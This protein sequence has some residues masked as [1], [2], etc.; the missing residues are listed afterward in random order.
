MANN[1]KITSEKLKSMNPRNI[2]ELKTSAGFCH[3][4][5][6]EKLTL[7]LKNKTF[8]FSPITNANDIDEANLHK[9]DGKNIYT[10]CLCNSDTEKIP[11]WYLY[12]GITGK[13]A[14][15]CLKYG[16][17]KKFIN[18]IDTVTTDTN[19]TLVK[20][21]DFDL[22]FGRI[23]YR[24]NDLKAVKHKSDFYE[25]EDYDNFNKDNYFIK[26]YSWEY[27]K[28]FRI[29]I[30]VKNGEQYDCLYADIPDEV[31]DKFKIKFAPEMTKEEIRQT[32]EENR[33]LLDYLIDKFEC[34][35]L[36]IKMGLLNRF[37]DDIR[38]VAF[39]SFETFFNRKEDFEKICG[40]IKNKGECEN[41]SE[42]AIV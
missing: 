17:I 11:M 25:L 35:K 13:G 19:K 34:S 14:R 16:N 32:V 8:R 20:G 3:Y 10:F 4:T 23:F 24:R 12:A 33:V 37:H 31:L 9:E 28:E 2:E 29:I 21:R 5:S 15:I 18:S 26:N 7:I 6:V 22:E 27:E 38:N 40:I 30:K 1:K 36:D 41:D 42:P 39:D